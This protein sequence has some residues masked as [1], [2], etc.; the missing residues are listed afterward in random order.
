MM[1]VIYPIVRAWTL[2]PK[3]MQQ[4]RQ[5][6]CVLKPGIAPNVIKWTTYPVNIALKSLYKQFLYASDSQVRRSEID[7]IVFHIWAQ[8]ASMLERATAAGYTGSLKLFPVAIG[9]IFW[10]GTAIRTGWLPCLNQ[11]IVKFECNG[12]DRVDVELSFDAAKWP[13]KAGTNEPLQSTERGQELEYGQS[14][15]HVRTLG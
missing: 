13:R 2:R 12:N 15:K 6:I 11:S 8:V 1:E 14:F 5:H 4:L 3:I 10:I 7:P 9:K